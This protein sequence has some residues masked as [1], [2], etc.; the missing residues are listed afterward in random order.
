MKVIVRS[1]RKSSR[2]ALQLTAAV[3]AL[4]GLP[5]RQERGVYGSY[6]KFVTTFTSYA[7]TLPVPVFEERALH[8]NRQ[9]R[10]GDCAEA[11]Q[12]DDF[13]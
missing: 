11:T 6:E 3:D 13:L 2:T 1:A 9:M 10:A 12:G 8:S 7:R 5:M 4:P